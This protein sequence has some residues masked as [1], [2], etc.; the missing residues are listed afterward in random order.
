MASRTKQKEE[1]RAR[2]LAE[3]QT[4]AERERRQ[5]RVRMLGGVVVAAIAVA[6]VLIAVSSGSSGNKAVKP[7]SPQATKTAKQVNSLLA[8]IPQAGNTLGNP[9]AKVTVTEFGDLECPICRDFALGAANQLIAKDVRSGKVKLVYRS[10]D[11]ATGNGVTPSM[12]G[13]Q[14]AA[15]L[16]AG[17][18]GKEWYYVELFYHEQGTEGTDYVTQTYLNGLAKQIVPY[19]LNYNKWFSAS[20]SSTLQQQVTQ[21]ENIASAKGYNSTPTIAISG[22]KGD[23]QP[24]VGNTDYGTVESTINQVS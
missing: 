7:N 5:R 24:I 23:A 10:L 12:F 14:Q 1:A 18:Q 16:A 4:R 11:T 3:E 8:G 9:S 19:G 22:P 15:A 6:A 2:R 17:L 13:P 20:Q 21:D